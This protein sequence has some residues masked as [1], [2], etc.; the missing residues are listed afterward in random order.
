MAFW[1]LLASAPL[2]VFF[3][4][5]A[6]PRGRAAFT[7]CAIA[8]AVIGLLWAAYFLDVAGLLGSGPGRRGHLT[9]GLVALSAAWAVAGS[10]QGLRLR[11]PDRWPGW[12]WPA[13]VAVTFGVVMLAI[14]RMLGI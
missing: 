9:L 11:L 1:G 4:L 7:G 13:T 10:L 3:A 2:A 6:L 5:V 8:G 12:V 14:L